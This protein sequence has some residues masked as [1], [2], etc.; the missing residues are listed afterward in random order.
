MKIHCAQARPNKLGRARNCFG[1]TNKTLSPFLPVAS[2]QSEHACMPC[3]ILS[4]SQDAVAWLLRA[5]PEDKN[6]CYCYIDHET[7]PFFAMS[8]PALVASSVV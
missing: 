3:Q 6:Q 5:G 2:M 1:E 4:G 8:S 7:A